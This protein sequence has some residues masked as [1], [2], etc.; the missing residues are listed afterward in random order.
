M[1]LTGQQQQ[2]AEA[3]TV[4]LDK[5]N[6]SETRIKNGG[7][8]RSAGAPNESDDGDEADE[9]G[10]WEL[11]GSKTLRKQQQQQHQARSISRTAGDAVSSSSRRR[12]AD[13]GNG[14][15]S[16]AV[17]SSSCSSA[18]S[19]KPHVCADGNNNIDVDS[20]AD[21]ITDKVKWPINVWNQ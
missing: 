21:L 1:R 9:G 15:R 13:E 6:N 4:R 12:R 19:T 5:N 14:S 11:A 16:K 18:S 7:P 17:S 10:E 8:I 2:A 20:V 3:E